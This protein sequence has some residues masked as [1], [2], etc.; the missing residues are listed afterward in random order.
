[1][2]TL[3]IEWT[4][5]P[6][7]TGYYTGFESVDFDDDQNVDIYEWEE[8]LL[9]QAARKLCWHGKLKRVNTMLSAR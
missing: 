8:K 1:M 5:G 2:K 6:N 4:T 3:T 9:R 7:M